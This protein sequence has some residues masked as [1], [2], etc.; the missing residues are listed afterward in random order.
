VGPAALDA[1]L[2][3]LADNARVEALYIQNFERVRSPGASERLQRQS[4]AQAVLK[5]AVGAARCLPLGCGG[6]A[7]HWALHLSAV[8]LI[9]SSSRNSSTVVSE[10]KQGILASYLPQLASRRPAARGA[11]G[12]GNE[13]L[14]HLT[15]VLLQRRIWALNVGENFQ[16]TLAAWQEFAVRPALGSPYTLT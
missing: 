1:V 11:Q 4:A 2:D 8:C 6:I 15:A 7:G 10:A 13:Q 3:A 12:F 14:R 16:V 5:A 9:V